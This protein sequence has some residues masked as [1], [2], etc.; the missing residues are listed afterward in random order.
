MGTYTVLVVPLVVV[1]SPITAV[2]ALVSTGNPAIDAPVANAVFKAVTKLAC[3]AVLS[4]LIVAATII[5]P[6][7]KV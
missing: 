5:E 7:F 3:W 1:L 4:T 2:N 6:D